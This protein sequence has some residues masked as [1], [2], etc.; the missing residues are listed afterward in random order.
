AF[1][2]FYPEITGREY[3]LQH[4]TQFLAGRIADISKLMKRPFPKK[5][6]FHDPCYLGRHNGEYEAPRTLLNTVPGM[7]FVEMYRCREQ[8]YC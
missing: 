1:K 4:Y 6:T 3:N 7:E 8:G 5:V 2:K